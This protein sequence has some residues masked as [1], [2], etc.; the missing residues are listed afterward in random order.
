MV[1]RDASSSSALLFGEKHTP[2]VK[3][4]K[5]APPEIQSSRMIAMEIVGI[6]G[7]RVIVHMDTQ[8]AD[9][10]IWIHNWPDINEPMNKI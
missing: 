10:P 1:L 8:D 3:S 6:I 2:L 4:T 9:C 7:S 5:F